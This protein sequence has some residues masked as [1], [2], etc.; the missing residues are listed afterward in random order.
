MEQLAM[1]HHAAIPEFGVIV[2]ARARPHP[3]N[4]AGRGFPS[5]TVV[6]RY[7]QSKFL[8]INLMEDDML[9]RAALTQP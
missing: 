9:E 3:F 2:G 6:S 5:S 4:D 7:L 8:E 1:N